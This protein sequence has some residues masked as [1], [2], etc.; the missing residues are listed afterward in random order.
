MVDFLVKIGRF[1][2][3][4]KYLVSA[5]KSSWSELGGQPNR[6]FPFS[7]ASVENTL[8]YFIHTVGDE[9]KSNYNVDTRKE[10]CHMDI[11]RFELSL[12]LQLT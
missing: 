6:A 11:F 3:K 5:I 12:N 7:T 9:L 8:A 2:K 1:V 4:K 10:R